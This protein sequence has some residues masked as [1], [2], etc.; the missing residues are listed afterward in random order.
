MSQFDLESHPR[1]HPFLVVRVPVWMTNQLASLV[2]Q[3]QG[4]GSHVPRTLKAEAASRRRGAS[5]DPGTAGVR[6]GPPSAGGSPK[7]PQTQA[8]KK[9]TKKRAPRGAE[10]AGS[11][12]GTGVRQPGDSGRPGHSGRGHPRDLLPGLVFPVVPLRVSMD[13]VKQVKFQ[14]V[15]LFF[16]RHSDNIC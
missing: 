8:D 12:D 3:A 16:F 11:W 6:K 15:F 1:V 9:R 14:L 13:A 4:R 10:G 2:L 7:G 5:A